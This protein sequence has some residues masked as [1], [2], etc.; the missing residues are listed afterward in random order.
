MQSGLPY[1]AAVS[2]FTGPGIVS[3]WNGS[4]GTALIP[5]LGLN[6]YKQPRK[7]VDDLR[8][9]KDFR[10]YKDYNLELLAQ[11]FNIANHQNIDGINS[12]AYKLGGT[13]TAGTATYQSTFQQITSSNNSGFLYTPRQI[14]IAAKF[15]F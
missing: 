2:G 4:G 5:G 11:M 14:E 9:E 6:T 7:I 12:T 15:T 1:S 10:V 8:V 13:G 3:D